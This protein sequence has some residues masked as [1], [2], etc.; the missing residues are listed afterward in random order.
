MAASQPETL[1]PGCCSIVEWTLS[2]QYDPTKAVLIDASH[3]NPPRAIS[4]HK[5][6]E[7]IASLVGAFEKDTTVCLH[8]S[9]DILYPILVLAIYGSSCRWTG[10]NTSYAIPEL[11]HHIQVS[12]AKY[13]ITAEEH[14][15]TVRAAAGSA[16]VILFTDILYE[17]RDES[18]DSL[19]GL[20]T[21]HDLCRKSTVESLYATIR[22][23]D[24]ESVSTLA[25]TSGTTGRPKMAARTQRA[26]VLESAAIE[27]ASKPYPVRRLY[28][29]P[30]FHG[31][32][33]PEMIINSLRRGVPSY[34]MKRYD[35]FSFA[36]NI[37]EFVIT[38]TFAPPPMLVRLVNNATEVQK[39][40]QSLR[41]VYT[42]GAALV[43]E[44]RAKFLKLFNPSDPPLVIQV[45]GMMECGWMTTFK[46]PEND[47]TSSIGRLM[48]GCQ[49]KLSIDRQTL[50]GGQEV[51]E[52]YAHSPYGMSCYWGNRDAT[53][54]AFED[55]DHYW[56]KTGD[57]GYVRDGKVYVVDREKEIFKVNGFQVAPP[58][59]E[60][61]FMA[62][63]GVKD[64]GVIGSGQLEDSGERPIAFVVRADSSVTAEEL[65]RQLGHR[66]SRYKVNQCDIR[67]LKAIPKS[68]T[69]KILKNELRK[70]AASPGGDAVRRTF[71]EQEPRQGGTGA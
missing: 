32:S 18:H 42:G 64:A 23:I 9:N 14:L 36:E 68:V 34:F 33:A 66:L 4:K 60:D 65:K 57:I 3:S 47:C 41:T 53:D 61:A 8:L 59:L 6:T 12:D 10:T 29:T 54:R 22:N 19:H 63:G 25:S 70:L 30:I 17:R 40:L 52:M 43:P 2:G 45:W 5:A 15:D 27:E 7:L 16:E 26:M 56:L 37:Q 48:S 50:P 69:G 71:E 39:K 11:E 44:L 62:L 20:R 13:V 51:G 31:L 58:E 24:L 46:Y 67:F 38:E 55:K 28:C 21:L 49:I 35:D 1:Q